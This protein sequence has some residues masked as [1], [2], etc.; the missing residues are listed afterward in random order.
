MAVRRAGEEARRVLWIARAHRI[1]HDPRHWIVRQ[2]AP[3]A[4]HEA[5]AGRQHP[6]RLAVARDL[7]GK[8]H[9]A[10]LAH[11]DVEASVGERQLQRIRLPDLDPLQRR[12]GRGMIDHRLVEVGGDQ[13]GR[14]G[15]AFGERRRD[16]ARAG[17]GLEHAGRLEVSDLARDVARK[18][19]EQQRAKIAVVERRDR[20]REDRIVAGHRYTFSMFQKVMAGAVSRP[21]TLL[22]SAVGTVNWPSWTYVGYSRSRA[23]AASAIAWRFAGSVSR[24]KASRSFSISASH[25]QP[26]TAFSQ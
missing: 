13:R 12:L 4:Q 6:P 5:A 11:H 7:V 14:R 18:R 23:W 21:F 9:D 3:D 24:A 2:A 10:E 15:Q 22:R 20:A 19:L 25:G 16:D 17:R 26:N 1:D 8:E